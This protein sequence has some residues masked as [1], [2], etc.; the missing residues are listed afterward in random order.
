MDAALA[1]FLGSKV[2]GVDSKV[3]EI[4]DSLGLKISAFLDPSDFA[5]VSLQSITTPDMAKDQTW[6]A[7]TA[8][9]D[10]TNKNKLF[11]SHELMGYAQN[12]SSNFTY[13]AV[14]VSVGGVV[15]YTQSNSSYSRNSTPPNNKKIHMKDIDV[16]SHTG[17][18]TVT[19]KYKT[20]YSGADA[21]GLGSGWGSL[22]N[23]H[24]DDKSI[25]TNLS[26]VIDTRTGFLRLGQTFNITTP[27]LVLSSVIEY[28]KAI[29]IADDVD[30][31]LIVDIRDSTDWSTILTGVVNGQDVSVIRSRGTNFLLKNRLSGA[32]QTK[33]VL[34]KALGYKYLGG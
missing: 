13:L 24:L 28:D 12:G 26:R 31:N 23:L 33:D 6:D 15:V 1:G 32:L 20:T 14:E 5:S 29:I 25:S 7:L 11:I 27:N 18:K 19:V 17:V 8:S 16:S 34:V 3:Q 22:L 9:V 21:S 30:N 2:D 10:F 4:L